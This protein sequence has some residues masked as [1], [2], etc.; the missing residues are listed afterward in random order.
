MNHHTVSH[1]GPSIQRKK[2]W[3]LVKKHQGAAL[4]SKDVPEQ[5]I[6]KQG[7]LLGRHSFGR[8]TACVV[9]L[10]VDTSLAS[11]SKDDSITSRTLDSL[12]AIFPA[13]PPE[14]A[15]V[16]TMPWTKSGCCCL[17]VRTQAESIAVSIGSRMTTCSFSNS[18]SSPPV[19]QKK[20]VS[21]HTVEFQTH[22][23]ILGDNPATSRGPPLSIGRPILG[24]ESLAIDDYEGHRPPRRSRGDLIVPHSV[25]VRMLMEAGY[26]REE[27]RTMEAKLLKIKTARRANATEGL[28]ERARKFFERNGKHTIDANHLICDHV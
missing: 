13:S 26:S 19:V 24:R 16:G 18:S 27:L 10:P 6:T 8:R 5:A 12:H 7:L 15:V 2:R 22:E 17:K 25:R 23:M 1:R 21:W 3:S 11:T 4:L 9:V 20:N 28:L 14:E